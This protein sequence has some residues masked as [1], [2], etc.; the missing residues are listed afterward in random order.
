MEQILKYLLFLMIGIIIYILYNGINGINGI[1][2]FN[3]GVQFKVVWDG[4]ETDYFENIIDAQQFRIEHDAEDYPNMRIINNAGVPIDELTHPQTEPEAE[5]GVPDSITITISIISGTFQLQVPTIYTL[6]QL[7]DMINRAMEIDSPDFRYRLI[8]NGTGGLVLDEVMDTLS[9]G[10]RN[11]RQH[12]VDYREVFPTYTAV[13]HPGNTSI[14]GMTMIS[15]RILDRIREINNCM[16][17]IQ[18][19]VRNITVHLGQ[20]YT[21]LYTQVLGR[22]QSSRLEPYQRPENVRYRNR[23]YRDQPQYLLEPY[24]ILE[25]ING[26]E[27]EKD[28]FDRVFTK[29]NT[30]ISRNLERINENKSEYDLIRYHYL[31]S[32]YAPP[33]TQIE[34]QQILDRIFERF[35]NIDRL[36]SLLFDMLDGMFTLE[37]TLVDVLVYDNVVENGLTLVLRLPP[38]DEHF[39]ACASEGVPPSTN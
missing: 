32:N 28:R 21:T 20:R 31:V 27:S 6:Q 24:N 29:V 33:N 22:N 36:L 30:I 16:T 19:Y 12:Y 1:N 3:V 2:G 37:P 4:G 25:Y 17:E 13:T 5:E 18:N 15:I 39:S 38:D 26:T 23:R 14:Q 9:E 8:L 10:I 11:L 35:Q 34:E 7:Q